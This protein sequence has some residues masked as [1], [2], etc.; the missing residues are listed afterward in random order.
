MC[1]HGSLLERFFKRNK[2][3]HIQECFELFR[4]SGVN[5]MQLNFSNVNLLPLS[6]VNRKMTISL[7][8][9]YLRFKDLFLRRLLLLEGKYGQAKFSRLHQTTSS[10]TPRTPTALKKAYYKRRQ[11][12]N[13]SENEP[14]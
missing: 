10:N 1:V 2:T 9:R 14:R 13:Y 3:E 7:V 5:N 4:A 8:E 6:Y 11:T 12:E